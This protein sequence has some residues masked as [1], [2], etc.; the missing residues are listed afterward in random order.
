MLRAQQS[1]SVNVELDVAPPVDLEKVLKEVREQYEGVIQ[2]NHQE[3]EKWFQGKVSDCTLIM[4][5]QLF[6]NTMAAFSS[7]FGR[8]WTIAL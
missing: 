2:K 3:A 4:F 8:Q 1:G 5:W 7:L 6:P